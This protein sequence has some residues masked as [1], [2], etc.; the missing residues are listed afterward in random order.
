M[1][2]I[3][4]T[5]TVATGTNQYGTGNKYYINGEANVVLYLQEGN[6]YIFDQS[7]TTNKAHTF[8]IF[9]YC[10]WNTRYTSRCRLIL[11]V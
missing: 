2:T 6:T 4:Y 10:K 5:V 11:L 9:N 8:S 7:D 3:T 1:A